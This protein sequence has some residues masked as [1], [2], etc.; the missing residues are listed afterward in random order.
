MP[1]DSD[2]KEPLLLTATLTEDNQKRIFTLDDLAY[3]EISLL[4]TS[5]TNR[6]YLAQGPDGKVVIK[7]LN[8]Y[9]TAAQNSPEKAKILELFERE[10]K[11]LRQLDHPQIPK[12]LQPFQIIQSGETQLYSM[13]EYLEG[14]NLDI[15][16]E[17]RGKF[18]PQEAITILL[19]AITP[20]Q[21]LHEQTPSVIHRDVK[22]ANI[23]W[24][25]LDA[26]LV[27]LGSAR[28]KNQD[29]LNLG[30]STIAGTSGYMAPEQW[31]GF[32]SPQS[33]I[34]GLGATLLRMITGAD[35]TTFYDQT[36]SDFE[37]RFAI[38]YKTKVG[39]Q[40]DES[41]QAILDQCLAPEAEQ[42]YTSLTK[43]RSDLEKYLETP[44]PKKQPN[45]KNTPSPPAKKNDMPNWL[46]ATI[47][48]AAAVVIGGAFYADHQHKHCHIPL[49]DQVSVRV[50]DKGTVIEDKH[51]LPSEMNQSICH[52]E[53]VYDYQKQGQASITQKIKDNT[54]A[55]YPFQSMLKYKITD[56][57][58]V[59]LSTQRI[60]EGGISFG[61]ENLHQLIQDFLKKQVEKYLSTISIKN[62][63]P[64]TRPLERNEIK[65]S[66]PLE[67]YIKI[68]FAQA[69][70]IGI[71]FTGFD[72]TIGMEDKK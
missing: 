58:A 56:P 49:Y 13:Q 70:S 30:S 31:I 12:F 24:D 22:P 59:H 5:E 61:E 53:R 48:G 9:F 8:A 15:I 63:P 17:H 36:Q 44:T 35:V 71:E 52:E 60:R 67:D 41:L 14:K 37:K 64:K 57:V 1:S 20:L 42:R 28:N 3:R 66:N 25:G 6:T 55:S 68:Q 38:S 29:S 51:E 40:I 7:S 43:L 50:N 69:F 2:R 46:I 39:E 19:S 16:L 10:S 32:A 4:G 33:D 47:M 65:Q 11:I 34:Y 45:K 62:L 18:S 23:L 26:K 72:Y 27:D 21:Y 54:K